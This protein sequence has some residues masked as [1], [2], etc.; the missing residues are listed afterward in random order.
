[1]LAAGLKAK[2]F[3]EELSLKDNTQSQIPVAVSSVSSSSKAPRTKPA[4][5]VDPVRANDVS[6]EMKTTELMPSV[7]EK[8]RVSGWLATSTEFKPELNNI[9]FKD[10]RVYLVRWQLPT[11]VQSDSFGRRQNALRCR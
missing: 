10:R 2:L 6:L 4:P 1:M 5:T 8:R 3:S 11:L 9:S 7:E